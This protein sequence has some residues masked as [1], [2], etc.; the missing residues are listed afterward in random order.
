MYKLSQLQQ[1]T[2]RKAEQQRKLCRDWLVYIMTS[3]PAKTRT[4]EDLCA[5][6]M[7]RFRV[8]KSAFDFGWIWAIEDTGNHHWYDPLPRSR[9]KKE[10]MKT[11]HWAPPPKA[12][13]DDLPAEKTIATNTK[14]ATIPTATNT[15]KLQVYVDFHG[16]GRSFAVRTVRPNYLAGTRISGQN[17]PLNVLFGPET[18]MEKDKSQETQKTNADLRKSQQ[19]RHGAIATAEYWERDAAMATK[20]SGLRDQRLAREAD[21]A[22]AGD[23]TENPNGQRKA[24]SK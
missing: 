11:Q 15:N 13:R 2:T 14:L 5:E 4:K 21:A 7:E 24:G 8:S 6:A 9:A 20:T 3:S 1:E 22:A 12:S 23:E 17:I 19:A 16:L 18:S 10:K